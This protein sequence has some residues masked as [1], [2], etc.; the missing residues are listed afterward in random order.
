M[1]DNARSLIWDF[2]KI[3]IS[4]S[5]CSSNPSFLRPVPTTTFLPCLQTYISFSL[6]LFHILMSLSKMYLLMLACVPVLCRVMW[7]PGSKTANFTAKLHILPGALRLFVLL[8]PVAHAKNLLGFRY[9]YKR[10]YLANRH[11]TVHVGHF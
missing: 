5:L 2:K 7:H 3:Y 10:S 6:L 8:F 4:F 1:G 11:Q 9:L